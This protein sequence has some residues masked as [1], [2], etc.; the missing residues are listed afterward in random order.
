MTFSHV[1]EYTVDMYDVA[2]TEALLKRT[3]EWGLD[4]TVAG[5]TFAG[6]V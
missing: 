5:T 1:K 2:P 4:T 6:D 3:V